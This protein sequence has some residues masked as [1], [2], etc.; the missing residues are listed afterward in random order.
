MFRV[1]TFPSIL[2]TTNNMSED[3]YIL[4]GQKTDD[5][6]VLVPLSASIRPARMLLRKSRGLL[7]CGT[8]MDSKKETARST[9]HVCY[10]H[11]VELRSPEM[12]LRTGN[13]SSAFRC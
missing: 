4:P 1:R 12:G 7:G 2:E 9:E 11:K 10:L 13:Y 5:F 3:L 8:A 6:W